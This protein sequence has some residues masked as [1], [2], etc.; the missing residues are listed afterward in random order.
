[1]QGPEVRRRAVAGAAMVT[2]R[3]AAIRAIGLAGTIVLARLL[4]PDDFG[5]VRA[6]RSHSGV[7][8]ARPLV[9]PATAAIGAA[10]AAWIVSTR[11]P[12]TVATIVGALAAAAFLY[13]GLLLLIRRP[14]VVD[15]SGRLNPMIRL[16][17]ARA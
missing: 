1:M 2:V 8:I 14:P 16:T 9:V 4:V 17:F 13:I 15:T 12:A 10:V 5:L 7:S 3:G 6:V 11:M